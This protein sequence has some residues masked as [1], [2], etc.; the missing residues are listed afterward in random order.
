MSNETQSP[1][2]NIGD[3]DLIENGKGDKF[4]A[5][6]GPMGARVGLSK[7]GFL[8]TIVEPG[9]SAFPHHVHS[10]NDEAFFIIEGEG[11]YR[12]G[13]ESYPIKAGDLL[14]APAGGPD[15]AHQIINS[16]SETLKY[17]GVST[18]NEPDLV[19]YPDSDKFLVYARTENGSPRSA[20]FRHIGRTK[21][22]YDYWDG[23]A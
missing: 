10:A 14:A 18:T 11:T 2:L 6:L 20:G 15:M 3:V 19:E 9:K 7:L 17:I 1:I 8:L 16:G 12:F 13:D 5:K 22:S 23:E 21:D 4:H